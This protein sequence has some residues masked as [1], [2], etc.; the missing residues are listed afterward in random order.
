MNAF[1]MCEVEI[2]REVVGNLLLE[3]NVCRVDPRVSIVFTKHT[4]RCERRKAT[5]RWNIHDVGPDRQAL[6]V[7]A[8]E[9]RSAGDAKLLHAIV[10]D[11]TN[12]RKHVLPAVKNTCV[13]SQH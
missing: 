7:A 3:L 4:N 2:Q 9:G 1:R 10:C 13:R 6:T 12:L 11:R 5:Q 8:T